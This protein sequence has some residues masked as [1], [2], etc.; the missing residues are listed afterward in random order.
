MRLLPPIMIPIMNI[1]IKDIDSGIKCTL[2]KFAENTKLSGV[3]DMPEGW[4]A[5]QRGLDKLEKRGHV[6]LSWY[7]LGQS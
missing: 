2:S 7:Q 1:F 3:V 4:D 6:N 5:I